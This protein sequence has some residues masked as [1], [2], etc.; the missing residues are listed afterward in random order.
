MLTR[1]N[2]GDRH[3]FSCLRACIS[4]GKHLSPSLYNEIRQFFGCEF[5]NGIGTTE[6]LHIF[7]SARFGSEKPGSLGIPV[8]FYEVKIM[9]YKGAESPP[10]GVG[11]LAVKGP[12]GARY[13]RRNDEQAKYVKYGFNCTG[14]LA[15]RDE[16]G[17]SGLWEETMT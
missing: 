15:Y 2:E 14:D 16:D 1:K 11:C 5:L 6:L 10:G 17:F 3:K 7:I 9:N 13:W 4:A 8:P 12:V